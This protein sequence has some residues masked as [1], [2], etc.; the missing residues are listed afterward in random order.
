[1]DIYQKLA[2]IEDFRLRQELD[3]QL[4]QLVIRHPEVRQTGIPQEAIDR[5]RQGGVTLTEAYRL[6]RPTRTARTRADDEERAAL[7]ALGMT[8]EEVQ[9]YRRK[10]E[11]A[12]KEQA[13]NLKPLKF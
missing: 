4:R 11:A 7:K 13:I 12:R 6:C 1:M 3:E 9:A 2:E 5:Y 10:L 8:P